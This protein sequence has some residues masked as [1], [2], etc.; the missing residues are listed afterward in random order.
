MKKVDS[1]IQILQEE[2]IIRKK[3]YFALSQAT[4]ILREKGI[5]S[6]FDI[7]NR[8][9]KEKLEKGEIPQA[10][11][12]VGKPR[13]WRI[14]KDKNHK[15]SIPP[16][17]KVGDIKKSEEKVKSKLHI[18]TER[19]H[20]DDNDQVYLICPSCG[21]NVFVPAKYR[22]E[23]SLC[24]Y[25]CKRWFINT[26]ST[27]T[28]NNN[29]IKTNETTTLT[30]RQIN[31]FMGIVIFIIVLIIIFSGI[32][33]EPR[34]I[35]NRAVNKSVIEKEEEK[36]TPEIIYTE[37][38]KAFA[39]DFPGTCKVLFKE[40]QTD[41]PNAILFDSVKLI[42][43]SAMNIVQFKKEEAR[44]KREEYEAQEL[45]RRKIIE[46]NS[47]IH[48][49]A[50]AYPDGGLSCNIYLFS[51]DGKKQY[52]LD[53]KNITYSVYSTSGSII[54]P[55]GKITTTNT[56]SGLYIDIPLGRRIFEANLVTFNITTSTGKIY[57]LKRLPIRWE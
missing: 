16:K 4:K 35:H 21:V 39:D 27:T 30:N 23:H 40:M 32:F 31:W 28:Q 5:L 45:R 41:Y 11:K 49:D 10:K 50:A 33:Y 26:A 38:K 1:I 42:Y 37:I 20:R 53:A 56:K 2:L 55:I 48:G 54:N 9:L 46:S 7:A 8:Y 57:K 36:R 44:K 24:C 52:Y 17:T 15:I 29:N 25:N 22:H 6:E 19:T 3:S 47:Y 13:H 34:G 18:N 14:H 12:T 51:K 43:D